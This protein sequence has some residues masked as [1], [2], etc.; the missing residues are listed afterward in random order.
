MDRLASVAPR[1]RRKWFSCPREP[2]QRHATGIRAP[3]RG[4]SSMPIEL[5]VKIRQGKR[6]EKFRSAMARGGGRAIRRMGDQRASQKGPPPIRP[7]GCSRALGARHGSRALRVKPS[8]RTAAGH[9]DD[10]LVQL[11]CRHR[12]PDPEQPRLIETAHPM[13]AQCTARIA[14]NR[15]LLPQRSSPCCRM[16]VGALFPS[17]GGRL[18]PV[19][20]LFA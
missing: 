14:S 1:R 11:I 6:Q 15:G 13:G 20:C 2:R 5:T 16:R 4:P 12:R 19:I 9:G 17:G 18:R 8:W 7:C 3:S 10:Q